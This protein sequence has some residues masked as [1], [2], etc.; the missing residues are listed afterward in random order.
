MPKGLLVSLEG[1]DGCGK[2]TQVR[3]LLERLPAE[4]APLATREP[5]GTEVGE[6]IR[7]II[8]QKG[9]SLS[10]KAEIL[11]YMAARVE[12][13]SQVIVPALAEGKLVICDR[14]IDSSVAYQGYGAGGDLAWIDS[15]NRAATDGCRPQLT[16]L[17][18]L[19]VEEAIRRRGTGG[20]RIED[21]GRDFHQRVREGYLELAAREPDRFVVLDAT[22]SPEA[23]HRII[24]DTITARWEG[25]D[26]G[27]KP[28]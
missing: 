7:N 19:P 10:L 11:L 16:F 25:K 22:L 12:I 4:M 27:C 2:T 9:P 14:Y 21:R 17:L 23:L 5:G 15:L 6:K 24:K 20:D 3:L 26:R 13:V 8:L 18:D 28:V 1:I